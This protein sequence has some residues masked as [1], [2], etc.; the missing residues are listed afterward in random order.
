MTTPQREEAG[1]TTKSTTIDDVPK[2]EGASE[3]C[4]ATLHGLNNALLTI[5]LNSQLI[6]G[7]LPTYS[8][9]RRNLH[10]IERSAQRAG[11][12]VKRLLVA[13]SG[14]FQSD[15]SAGGCG[16]DWRNREE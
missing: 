5:L 15:L 1:K 2:A 3:E 12:L 7:K 8:K 16:G 11:V 6:D 4:A 14:H 10:E 13:H 9:I